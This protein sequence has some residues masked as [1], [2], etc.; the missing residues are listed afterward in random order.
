VRPV[1]KATIPESVL[2]YYGIT[3]PD[4]GVLGPSRRQEGC[5]NEQDSIEPSPTIRAA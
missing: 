1:T 5:F 4:I 3:K 2:T